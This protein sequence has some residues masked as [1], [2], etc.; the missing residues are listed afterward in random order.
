MSKMSE[1]SEL[2]QEVD[3]IKKE[4][5]NVTL[6]VTNHLPHMIQA[7]EASVKS[8]EGRLQPIETKNIKTQGVHEFLNISLKA[9]GLI[10]GIVWTVVLTVD[11]L[12]DL[13]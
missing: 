2:K 13:F 5:S 1:Y 12:K 4:V 3:E 9:T 6:H 10:L 7:V 11:K 8:L